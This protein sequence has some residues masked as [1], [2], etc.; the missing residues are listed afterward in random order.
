MKRHYFMVQK[1]HI[2]FALFR[3]CESKHLKLVYM[4]EHAVTV[5]RSP[6]ALPLTCSFLLLMHRQFESNVTKL[7][8]ICYDMA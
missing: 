2:I 5:G 6:S 3:L 1:T 7:L 8:K 4:A